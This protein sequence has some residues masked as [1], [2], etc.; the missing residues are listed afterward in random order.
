MNH[1]L[2]DHVLSIVI[3]E[4]TEARAAMKCQNCAATMSLMETKNYFYCEFC[5]G[6][7]FPG[8]NK[9]GFVVLQE[10]LDELVCPVCKTGMSLASISDHRVLHCTNCR[11]VYVANTTFRQIVDTLRSESNGPGTPQP[12]DLK[13]YE[14]S[15]DCPACER[16][17]KTHPYYGPGAV[18]IDSCSACHM[19]WLDHGELK[20]IVDA[21]SNA[22]R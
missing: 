1:S 14:R 10:A 8:E 13:E 5:G 21:S 2:F 4:H 20:V 3:R 11:G 7:D 15:V 19:I 12:I 17:M 16:R 18:V 6:F 9:E 22:R